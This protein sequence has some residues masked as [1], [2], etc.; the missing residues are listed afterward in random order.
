MSRLRRSE[1]YERRERRVASR[2]NSQSYVA[3][4]RNG[5]RGG[6]SSISLST[7]PLFVGNPKRRYRYLPPAVSARAPRNAAPPHR[8]PPLGGD[9]AR[10]LDSLAQ[11]WILDE[12]GVL[13]KCHRGHASHRARRPFQAIA[14]RGAQSHSD[15][16]TRLDE[17][18][19]PGHGRPGVTTR[20]APR[21][22]LGARLAAV[23]NS[24]PSSPMKVPGGH[25]RARACR[26]TKPSRPGRARQT[27]RAAVHV[28]VEVRCG[29]RAPRSVEG[30]RRR[31]R[32]VHRPRGARR[33]SAIASSVA[34]EPGG[35][36]GRTSPRPGASACRRRTEDGEHRPAAAMSRPKRASHGVH[37]TD[38]SVS[39]Y[40]PVRQSQALR[41]A[42]HRREG[43][44]RARQRRAA[45]VGTHNRQIRALGRR[46]APLGARLVGKRAHGAGFEHREEPRGHHLRDPTARR[47]T[48]RAVLYPARALVQR[49]RADRARHA[50]R[51]PSLFHVRLPCAHGTQFDMPAS[52]PG[53]DGARR[54]RVRCVPAEQPQ[55][56]AV[57]TSTHK[58]Q[59]SAATCPRR[60]PG[61]GAS[62]SAVVSAANVPAAHGSHWLKSVADALRPR[63]CPRDTSRA[64]GG[65]EEPLLKVPESEA[66]QFPRRDV[67]ERSR[68]TPRTLWR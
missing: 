21:A 55:R 48:P 58:V 54:A 12:P 18:L 62:N 56:L 4:R 49:V 50:R 2:I 65:R 51:L 19:P 16:P 3:S 45:G 38:P 24:A 27:Q 15:T 23:G 31:R 36:R 28:V 37:P 32:A 40:D 17:R 33:H 60:C 6:P 11:L 25:F 63:A 9:A 43:T 20:R 64:A 57:P 53:P 52:E 30:R 66:V 26:L 5:T 68:K 42:L 29:M 44:L 10:R 7:R 39:A 14:A 1:D 59:V 35:A 22:V 41:H 46:R 47:R 61:S 8:V 34:V 67:A 13:L